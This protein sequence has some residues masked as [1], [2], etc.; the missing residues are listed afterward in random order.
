MMQAKAELRTA[1]QGTQSCCTQQLTQQHSQMMQ[2]E[3]PP[4]A[5]AGQSMTVTA[6]N[7]QQYNVTVPPGVGGG[8]QGASVVVGHAHT[9]RERT[10]S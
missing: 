6:P 1:R 7:G 4:G 9:R 10:P 8:G 3:A 2:M 5:V